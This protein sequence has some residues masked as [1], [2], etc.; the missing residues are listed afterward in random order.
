[1][2][3]TGQTGHPTSYALLGIHPGPDT[4]AVTHLNENF[5]SLAGGTDD[6]LFGLPDEYREALVDIF[7]D[8]LGRSPCIAAHGMMGSSIVAFRAVALFLRNTDDQLWESTDDLIWQA[9][10]SA[11]TSS[12]AR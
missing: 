11:F 6:V 2:E 10:K 3:W 9:W 5:D 4:A 1:V 12:R 7:P 8:E